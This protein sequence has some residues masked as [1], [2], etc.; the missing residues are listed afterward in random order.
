MDFM[1]ERARLGK[2]AQKVLF[3]NC[4]DLKM[5]RDAVLAPLA[6]NSSVF[7]NTGPDQCERCENLKVEKFEGCS[8]QNDLSLQKSSEQRWFGRRA[9]FFLYRTFFQNEGSFFANVSAISQ[10]EGVQNL[11][12][13]LYRTLFG[14][15]A[16]NE[17]WPIRGHDLNFQG[18]RPW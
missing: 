6:I 2:P 5:Q 10:N 14:A 9:R 15:C 17:G 18:R 16:Q 12:V 3:G 8:V 1:W 4:T 11:K 13:A 7:E